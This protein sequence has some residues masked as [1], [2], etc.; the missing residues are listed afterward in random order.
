MDQ[1]SENDGQKVEKKRNTQVFFLI[2]IDP[3]QDQQTDAGPIQQ[4]GNQMTGRQYTVQVHLCQ[5]NRGAA[6]GDQ[7]DQTGEKHPADRTGS[8]DSGQ[9]LFS[10]EEKAQIQNDRNQK[11]EK[12]DMKG[13]F[14]GRGDDAS[15]FAMAVLLLA[16]PVNQKIF[17]VFRLTGFSAAA[18]MA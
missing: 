17:S 2:R 3:K 9:T 7:A 11:D 18:D 6:V 14:Q 12:N 10:Q 5:Q 13:V 1:H 4:A 15:V 16:E 8:N